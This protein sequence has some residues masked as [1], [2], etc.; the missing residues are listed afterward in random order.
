MSRYH[1]HVTYEEIADVAYDIDPN[2]CTLEGEIGICQC[3]GCLAGC[4]F[5]REGPFDYICLYYEDNG[6]CSCDKAKTDRLRKSM[7]GLP[8]KKNNHSFC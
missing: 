5:T 7:F 8:V 1:F 6:E 3:D 2:A 4:I